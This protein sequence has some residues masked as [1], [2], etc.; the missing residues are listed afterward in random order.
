[1]NKNKIKKNKSS[2]YCRFYGIKFLEDSF[3]IEIKFEEFNKFSGRRFTQI[4]SSV[5]MP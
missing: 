2:F 3:P 5:L 4:H 1:M